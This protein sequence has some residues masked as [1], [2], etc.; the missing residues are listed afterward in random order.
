MVLFLTLGSVKLTYI[1]LVI[2]TEVTRFEG[3]NTELSEHSLNTA[4][5]AVAMRSNP[6]WTETVAK[7]EGARRS[8]WGEYSG[9]CREGA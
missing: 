2:L 7:P 5:R 4:Q 3:Q 9:G 8:E 1:S 6:S